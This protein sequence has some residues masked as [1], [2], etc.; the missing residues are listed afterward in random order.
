MKIQEPIH[1]NP[2]CVSTWTLRDP[3]VAQIVAPLL[4]VNMWT[5]SGRRCCH[6]LNPTGDKQLQGMV[7]RC[8]GLTNGCCMTTLPTPHPQQTWTAG[9]DFSVFRDERCTVFQ[10]IARSVSVS[11]LGTQLRSPSHAD[12]KAVVCEP[13][14]KIQGR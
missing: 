7:A 6:L 4:P 14:P 11:F 12:S 9:H 1:L 8:G 3:Q 5:L 13:S 10:G 2:M